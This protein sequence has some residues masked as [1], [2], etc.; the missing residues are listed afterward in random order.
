MG[1]GPFDFMVEPAE[2]EHAGRCTSSPRRGV[3]YPWL[4]MGMSSATRCPRQGNQRGHSTF[5]SLR[6]MSPFSFS[7]SCSRLALFCCSVPTNEC[8]NPQGSCGRERGIWTR[9]TPLR[10]RLRPPTSAPASPR[11]RGLTCYPTERGPGESPGG[12]SGCSP[13]RRSCGPPRGSA[14]SGHSSRRPG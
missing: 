12:G 4:C 6:R 13:A 14:R 9:G 1:V 3:P 7:V 10:F 2:C 5:L 11:L 8:R